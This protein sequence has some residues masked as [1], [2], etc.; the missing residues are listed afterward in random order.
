MILATTTIAHHP[1][2]HEEAVLFFDEILLMQR[3]DDR[4]SLLYAIPNGG[5]R[6][7]SVG[8]YLKQEGVRRGVPDYF[9]AVPCGGYHGLY[10]ELK[11][12]TG[13]TSP[14][15]KE[16]LLALNQQGYKAVIA[17]GSDA[18]LTAVKE[19]LE[20]GRESSGTTTA[21]RSN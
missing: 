19:Y 11:T 14:E 16:W 4:L 8:A 9:L 7:K 21:L 15:Q 12:K 6:N 1:S 3:H 17:K 18:A 20:C 5:H 2:E 13:K 10:I